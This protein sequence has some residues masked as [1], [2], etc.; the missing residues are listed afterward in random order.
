VA[1]G[2]ADATCAVTCGSG[3]CGS[4]GACAPLPSGSACGPFTCANGAEQAGQWSA[5]TYR[6]KVCDGLNVGAAACKNNPSVLSC[7]N[8]VCADGSTCRTTCVL[9]ADCVAG[10]HCESNQCVGPKGEGTACTE[11]IECVSRVCGFDYDL[12]IKVCVKCYSTNSCPLGTASCEPTGTSGRGQ[13]VTC[14]NLR[15]GG[16]PSCLPD[17]SL[18]C[19]TAGCTARATDC[20]QST[21]HCQCGT[22]TAG[23][24]IGM[25]CISGACKVGALQP[26][27]RDDCAYGACRADGICGPSA[28]GQLCTGDYSFAECEGGN[29][30]GY[31]CH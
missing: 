22:M 12:G 26:C 14:A 3:A 1:P 23:C 2:T 18:D 10:T 17:G 15:G 20:N 7:G 30:C 4:N 28:S 5:A 8:N 25:F 21:G 6:N 13:C 24:A 16:D 11:G 29:S 19:R 31:V 27:V 9:D